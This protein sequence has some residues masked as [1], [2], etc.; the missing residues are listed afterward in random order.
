MEDDIFVSMAGAFD[1]ADV[2]ELVGLLL[3]HKLK[4]AVPG[5]F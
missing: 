4:E 5:G 2:A 1:G 3:L